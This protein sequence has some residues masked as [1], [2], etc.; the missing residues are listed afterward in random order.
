M[1]P[2]DIIPM[3]AALTQAWMAERT[4]A[5]SMAVT[6][7]D[8]VRGKG[9]P[10]CPVQST[11]SGAR[12][13]SGLIFRTAVEPDIAPLAALRTEVAERLTQE[14]GTGH[15]SGVVSE[16]GQRFA[17]NTSRVIVATCGDRIVGTL[18]LAT[19][20]PWAIDVSYFT[21]VKRALYVLD[22]AVSPGMQRQGT[23][24][25]LMEEAVRL[26]KAWPAQALRLDAYDGPVGAG[27]FY[28][29]CGL[30]ETGRVVYRKVPLVYFE[31]VW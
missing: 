21:P 8:V 7:P 28:A 24:R 5:D 10:S 12:T 22:L 3:A 27:P 11:M 15:W 20:K 19:K 1:Q 13:V 31:Y 30:R 26:A 14:F 23:G 29:R 18:R 6:E 2:A 25:R 17:M 4:A 9:G 16:R